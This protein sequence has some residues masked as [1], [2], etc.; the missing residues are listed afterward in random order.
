[1]GCCCREQRTF[2]GKAQDWTRLAAFPLHADASQGICRQKSFIDCPIKD[3][4]KG[5]DIAVYRRIGDFP[6]IVPA[7]AIFADKSLVNAPNRAI[8]KEREQ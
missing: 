5:L 4:T 3:V 7:G 6:F 2:I 1:M 8:G